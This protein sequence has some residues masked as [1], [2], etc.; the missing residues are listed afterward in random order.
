MSRS[1]RRAVAL[2]ELLVIVAVITVL[3]GLLLTA[4]KKV[5]A[6]AK[7]SCHPPAACAEQCQ[8]HTPHTPGGERGRLTGSGR[9]QGSGGIELTPARPDAG[10][11]AT[12]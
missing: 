12:R 1:R 4:V 10:A 11:N 3:I 9:T 8:R 2:T 7:A 5:S 6:A